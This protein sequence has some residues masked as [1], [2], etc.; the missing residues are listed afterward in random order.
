MF[1][2]SQGR[3][4]VPLEIDGP[5][6]APSIGVDLGQALS[7]KLDTDSAEDA[8]KGLLKGLLDRKKKKGS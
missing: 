7:L 5:L 4:A 8:V 6:L 1:V 2:D 3:L